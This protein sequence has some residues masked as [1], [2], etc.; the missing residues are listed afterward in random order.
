MAK[1]VLRNAIRLLAVAVCVSSIASLA[2]AQQTGG[3]SNSGSGTT[4]SSQAGGAAAT[5]P[6]AANAGQQLTSQN[7]FSTSGDIAGALGANAG[8]FATSNL[9]NAPT[10]TGTAQTTPATATGRNTNQFRTTQNNRGNTNQNRF[11]QSAGARPTIRPSLRLGFAAPPRP[12]V[13]VTRSVERR[14]NT[15][16]ARVSR[17]GDTTPAFRGVDIQVGDAGQVTLT[18]EV[19]SAQAA[20][21]AANILRMEA[22]VRSVQNDLTVAAK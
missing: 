15:L 3:T 19:A 2:E 14:M 18:G 5:Q 22:G 1:F 10:A 20:R 8:R 21:L 4:T 11:G 6:A 9:L 7:L 16:S 13:D 17:L 12:S